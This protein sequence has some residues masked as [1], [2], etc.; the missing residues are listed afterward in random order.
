MDYKLIDN[1]DIDIYNLTNYDKSNLYNNSDNIIVRIQ[2]EKDDEKIYVEIENNNNI[3]KN[4]YTFHKNNPYNNVS[5]RDLFDLSK[6][7]NIK[8][9]RGITIINSNIIFFTSFEYLLDKGAYNLYDC[10]GIKI[11]DIGLF[12]DITINLTLIYKKELLKISTFRKQIFYSYSN[13]TKIYTYANYKIIKIVLASANKQK[14]NMKIKFNNVLLKKSSEYYKHLYGYYYFYDVEHLSLLNIN[15]IIKNIR[16]LY[17]NIHIH[18]TI[19]Y[20]N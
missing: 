7:Y 16:N 2:H 5:L 9:Y 4:I 15:D 19:Y 17:N 1:I 8:N 14:F 10:C 13:D 12:K 20:Q 18:I 6:M 3:I 11:F